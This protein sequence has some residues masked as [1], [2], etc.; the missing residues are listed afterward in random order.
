MSIALS[1]PL[2]FWAAFESLLINKNLN[3]K[4][5]TPNKWILDVKCDHRSLKRRNSCHASLLPDFH[6]MSRKQ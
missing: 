4:Y 1:N 5:D 6:T 2:A 3:I